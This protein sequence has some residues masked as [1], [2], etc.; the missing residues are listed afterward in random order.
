MNHLVSPSNVDEKFPILCNQE[1]FILKGNSYKL[2][3][4]LPGFHIFINPAVKIDQDPG[5]PKN[6]M[7][8]CIP[9]SIKRYVKDVSP[10]HWRVQAVLISSE[11][12]STLLINSYFPFDTREQTGES[13]EL[14][15]TLEVIQNIIKE[16]SCNAIVWAGDIN[17]DFMRN[18]RHSRTVREAVSNLELIPLWE[19]HDVDFTCTYEREGVTYVSLLDHFFVSKE[20]LNHVTDAGVI[21]NTE[22]TSDHEPIYC[23]LETVTLKP[24]VK[25][26]APQKPRPSWKLANDEQKDQ[27]KYLLDV[28]LASIMIP[29]Q[30]SDCQDVHCR[31][32]VHLEACDWYTAEILEAVQDSAENSLPVPQGDKKGKKKVTPGFNHK[33]KPFKDTALFWNAVWKSAG[34]PLNTQ[35]HAVMKNSR[36]KYHYEFKKCERAE[37][38]IKKSKLLDAC[39]NGNG[40]LFKEIKSMRRTKPVCADQIDGVTEDLPGHFRSIY[41]ELYNSVED[42][43]EV[44]TIS[45]EVESEIS[46]K[47]LEDVNKVTIEEVKKATAALKPGKGDPIY[48]FSSDCMKVSSELLA[49]HISSMIKSFLIHGHI[50]QFLLL[51]TLVPIIKDKLGSINVSKNYRSVCLTSLIL[52]QID[53]VTISLFGENIGFHDL[54]FAY[55]SGVSSNMCTWAVTETVSY[56]LRNQSEVFGCSMDKSKAFDMCK[57]SILFRKM[58]GK[59]SHIFLRLIIFMYVNQFSNV[60]FN[61]EVSSSFT[62]TNGVGQGKILAGFAYCFYC[63][64]FFVQL[65]RS[66]LGCTI[67]GTYAGA[68]GYSDDDLLLAPTISALRGM[69]KISEEYCNLHG[70]KFSTDVENLS[71]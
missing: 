66:G 35:L 20:L 54:Q 4:A 59:I 13:E 68:Y 7:F 33:V 62:I 2:F 25:T 31:D 1:N 38:N 5:R 9:E 10:N 17:S 58:F 37:K 40:N 51:S 34:C 50:P 29:T 42:A 32:P 57:F 69:L 45:K 26:P 70:L 19:H 47:S 8:I 15:E 12:S 30:V 48:S 23:V 52:K 3:Q 61:S 21:H 65:E 71:P 28:R 67:N 41:E 14:V 49:E 18:N 55:Q 53:W 46:E 64:D 27:Y 56:F 39:L 11:N 63:H 16:T 6:G 43:H 36:N 60:C 22:N 44:E 24:S